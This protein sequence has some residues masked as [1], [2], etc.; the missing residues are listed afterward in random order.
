MTQS[1]EFFQIRPERSA[2]QAPPNRSNH[3]EH[4][5]IRSPLIRTAP[6]KT[7]DVGIEHKGEIRNRH[8]F[9]KTVLEKPQFELPQR[10]FAPT[11]KGFQFPSLSTL[12]R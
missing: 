12:F 5:N 9:R 10:E 6:M 7:C 11:R 2:L 3:L 8:C 1:G 4:K